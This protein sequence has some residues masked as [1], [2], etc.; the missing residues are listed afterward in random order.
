MTCLNVGLLRICQVF[1][2]PLKLCIGG[3]WQIP[4]SRM[5]KRFCWKTGGK[6]WRVGPGHR[7]QDDIKLAFKQIRFEGVNEVMSRM[8][9]RKETNVLPS[10]QTASCTRSILG[11]RVR[12]GT[13]RVL[14]LGLYTSC[15][16]LMFQLRTGA[17][18]WVG[19]SD[20]WLRLWAESVR[21][22]A[23]RRRVC[24]V[25]FANLHSAVKLHVHLMSLQIRFLP[26]VPR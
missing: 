18:P 8:T 26:P 20:E 17:Y 15:V 9:L 19:S 25:F 6:R 4:V 22:E 2:S 13:F 16:C 24:S 12:C 11:R 3:L 7:W 23:R 21:E 14:H 5:I 1:L 10:R